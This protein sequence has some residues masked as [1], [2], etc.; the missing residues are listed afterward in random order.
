MVIDTC[1]ANVDKGYHCRKLMQCL[2][3]AALGR[4]SAHSNAVLP[5]LHHVVCKLCFGL[6]PLR[7]PFN[8][9]VYVCLEHPKPPRMC[10]VCLS[11]GRREGGA[12]ETHRL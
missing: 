2:F 3:P 12:A 9:G 6:N 7:V 5:L 11:Y 10:F 4:R 8:P 1:C